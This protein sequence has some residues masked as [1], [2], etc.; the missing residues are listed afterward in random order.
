MSFSKILV[1]LLELCVFVFEL[2]DFFDHSQLVVTMEIVILFEL[3]TLLA[4]SIIQNFYFIFIVPFDL[5]Y[6]DSSRP[7]VEFIL[8][9]KLLK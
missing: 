4:Q 1:D 9:G 5:V 6:L 7:F 2:I 8:V 3:L